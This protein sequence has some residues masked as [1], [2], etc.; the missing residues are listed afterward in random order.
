[1][2]TLAGID[3]GGTQIKGVLISEMGE[4]LWKDCL[5]T[6]DLP[7]ENWKERVKQM[8]I[9]LKDVA[10]KEFSK[11]GLSAPGLP[12]ASNSCISFLPDRLCGLEQFEW[13]NFLEVP[14]KVINDAHAA[15]MAEF[16]FGAGKPFTNFILLTLGTGVGGGLILNG[17]LHQ[18]LSQMAGHIGHINVN[19]SQNETSILGMPGSLEFAIGNCS[20]A[21]RSQG[22]FTE[23]DEL[24]RAYLQ[25]DTWASLIWLQSL[26]SLATALCSLINVFSPEAIILAGGI[27]LAKEALFKPLNDFMDIYEFRPAGKT[28]QILPAIFNDYSGAIGAAAF[29]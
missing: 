6:K 20:L 7:G 16:K 15:T 29:V 9:K 22:R 19:N 10:G 28:T 14:T 17:Q 8:V 11:L 21:E 2:K 12:N 13:S 26:K 3:L 18:G 4:I 5:E 1:M 25:G 27:T 23:T 24:V